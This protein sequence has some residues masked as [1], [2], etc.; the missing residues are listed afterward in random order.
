MDDDTILDR[1][2]D[3]VQEVHELQERAAEDDGLDAGDAALLRGLEVERDRCWDLLRRRRALRAAGGDPD[4]A[5]VQDGETVESY[6][7]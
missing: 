2:D 4:D 5:E 1:I 7:Q 3:L 6:Q